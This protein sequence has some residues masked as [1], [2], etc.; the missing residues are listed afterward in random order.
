LRAQVLYAANDDGIE[1]PVID[2]TNPAFAMTVTDAEVMAMAYQYVSQLAQQ[3]AMAPEIEAALKQSPLG[4][5]IQE[6]AGSYL[7]GLP[8]Y[9][10]KLG[11]DNLGAAESSPIDR[12]IVA[13][14]AALSMRMRLED[15]ARLVAD[16][17]DG[18]AAS[19]PRRPLCMV[20]IA[21]G[22]AS[23]SWNALI[24][25]RAEKPELL[26]GREV[27]I[28]VLDLDEKGPAFGARAVAALRKANE[29]LS[30]IDV[31][32]RHFHYAWSDTGRL[33]QLLDELHASDTACAISSEGGLFEYGS[34][35]EIVSNLEVLHAGTAGDAV[36]V[37][38]VT[39]D[40][41]L[42]R[43]WQ[44]THRMNIR[45]RTM[46]AF[47]ALADEAGWR[48]DRVIDRPLSY[49]ALLAKS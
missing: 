30:G 6:G 26:E 16:G 24:L 4:R 15:M 9:I 35:A 2:I 29:P 43:I 36:V 19:E 17:L 27:V 10:L 49:D 20:N 33:R 41:E 31:R 18:A 45:P 47:R 21:G 22:P 44:A 42:M 1:L 38:S 7:P 28:A 32:M 13:S 39:R 14:F 48:V 40:S 3:T 23:D 12:H 34:D 8:T 46:E 37:G 11:P 25:L 5:A